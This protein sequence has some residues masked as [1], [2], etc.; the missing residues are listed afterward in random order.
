MEIFDFEPTVIYSPVEGLEAEKMLKGWS[1]I[2]H[3]V[4]E[5]KLVDLQNA[6]NQ[7]QNYLDFEDNL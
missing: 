4:K 5:G 7:R 6:T 3:L 2:A 1:Y